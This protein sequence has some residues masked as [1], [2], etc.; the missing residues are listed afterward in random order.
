MS[1][2]TWGTGRVPRLQRTYRA[3]RATVYSALTDRDKLPAW[4]GPHG[5]SAAIVTLDPR[6]GGGYE[7]AMQP[8]AGDLFHISGEFKEVEPPARLVYTFQDDPQ[9]PTIARRS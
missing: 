6:V 4:F 9:P 8:P 1:E 2:M 5:F 7:I 3:S